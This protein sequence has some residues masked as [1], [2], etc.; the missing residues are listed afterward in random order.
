ML[1][2]FIVKLSVLGYNLNHK[3]ILSPISNTLFLYYALKFMITKYQLKTFS[4][5]LVYVG[6]IN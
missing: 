3:S 2:P 1:R 6:I 5:S 4:P